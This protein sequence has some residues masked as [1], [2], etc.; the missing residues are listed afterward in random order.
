MECFVTG[1]ARVH[2][3]RGSAVAVAG[4]ALWIGS[5]M[6]WAQSAVEVDVGVAN[7]HAGKIPDDF[8][9]LSFESSNLL[10]D[11]NGRYLFSDQDEQLVDAFT[12]IGIRNLRVGGG[13]ADDPRYAIPDKKDIDELFGFARAAHVKVI[14]TLRLFD[15]NAASDAQIAKYIADHYRSQL[16]CFQIGNEPD[17]HSYHSAPNHPGDP[18]IVETDPG[19][20]GSA[21]PSYL[22]TWNDFAAA[23]DL[24]VPDAPFTGPDT[25]SNYPVPGTKDTDYR[26][27]SWTQRFAE[28]EKASNRLVF[29]T[30]HD[31]A[32]QGAAG[33][34]VKAAVNAMLSA[35]WPTKRYEVLF[36]HVLRPVLADGLSYRMTEAND[37]TGGV[38]GASNAFASA[39]W[40]LDYLH[41]HAE[42]RAAGVN[43]H[44]KRWIY[45][46]TVY[47]DG[48]GTLHI[49]P[50]AYAI[51]A[52]DIGSHGFVAP[53]TMKNP[54]GINVTAYAVQDDHVTLVTLINKEHGAAARAAKVELHAPGAAGE[55]QSMAMVAPGGDVTA[56]AGVTL[57]GSAITPGDWHG[58]WQPAGVIDGGHFM[59]TV[60][61]AS[62]LIVRLTTTLN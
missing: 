39:L 34:S 23:I 16:V 28:D 5:Q 36:D 46:D 21:Y 27:E 41:W 38:D 50:K 60:P 40:A 44:N 24:Q 32:G 9:G 30:Q 47:L 56:R 11:K 59:V 17:W 10:P 15:G 45:T 49:N 33:V 7:T 6:A 8:A 14:Y 22:K 31:Y 61:P 52:F 58:T 25:G 19:V 37:Y 18:R 20:P 43:F 55:V 3:L 51:R 12:A 42:H 48:S 26:G 62:A 35:D 2:V 57:G 54:D 53:V 1:W 4:L 29:V 13:T